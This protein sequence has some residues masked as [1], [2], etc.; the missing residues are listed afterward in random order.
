VDFLLLSAFDLLHLLQ[1]FASL[2]FFALLL[3]LFVFSHEFEFVF[4][5]AASIGAFIVRLFIF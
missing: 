2:L 4:V 1:L 3:D 5:I